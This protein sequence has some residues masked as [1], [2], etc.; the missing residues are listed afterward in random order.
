MTIKH[1][2]MDQID[3]AMQIY[4]NARAYMRQNGNKNQ[5]SNGYPSKEV[6]AEDIAQGRFYGV[7]DGGKLVCVFMMMVGVDPNYN[8][9]YDGSW[10][11]D[12]QYAVIHRIATIL[13]GKGVAE[14]CYNF[15]LAHCNNLRIDTSSENIPMQ[16]SLAKNGFVC[17]GVIH[18]ANG[19]PRLAY[20]KTI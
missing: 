16:K 3:D 7:Y 14:M 17:C 4:D 20:H 13:H 10:L 2:A 11:N 8:V 15:A 9:I 5:W 6:I 1:F 18:L 19:D 12:E